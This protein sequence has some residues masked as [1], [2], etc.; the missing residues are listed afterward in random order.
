MAVKPDISIIVPVYKVEPYLIQ[1]VESIRRQTLHNIEIILV[2]DG[3]P[4]Q[5]PKICDEFAEK[6]NRIQVL[7]QENAGVAAARNNGI[8]MASADWIMFV[9]SDDW[10]EKTAAEILYEKA[11]QSGCDIV[12]AAHYK[13]Y[14]NKQVYYTVTI[15]GDREY[16]VKQNL[17][18]LLGCVV[19]QMETRRR[20]SL[21]TPWGKLYRTSV[22]KMNQVRFPSDM[23]VSEDLVFNLYAIQHANKV[24]LIDTPVYHYRIAEGSLT[25]SLSNNQTDHVRRV[26]EELKL[27]MEKFQLRDRF[28]PFYTFL[29][30]RNIAVYA[31]LL[32]SSITDRE[33]FGIASARLKKLSQETDYKDAIADASLNFSSRKE[34]N[35][36]LWLL[37]HDMYRAIIAACCVYQKLSHCS[38]K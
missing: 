25:R 21:A 33:S 29:L 11:I 18:R 10:L 7:H 15:D 36:I 6:D 38:G 31:Q 8:Q 14:P 22:V 30:V 16:V 17:D 37:Q 32:S 28:Q 34:Y 23:R 13:N 19:G 2:D 35:I 26:Q 5:C 9:D 24:Y 12:C 1:C 27:F 4:D 20:R 3:S